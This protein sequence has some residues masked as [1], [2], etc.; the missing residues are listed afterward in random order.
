[1]LIER[2]RKPRTATQPD[3]GIVYRSESEFSGWPFLGGLWRI[4]SGQIV[5]AFT[6]LPCA[7]GGEADVHHNNLTVSQ[8]LVSII[9]SDDDGLTWKPDSVQTVFDKAMTAE[10]IA[11][12]GEPDYASEPAV[13][14]QSADTLV[15]SGGIPGLFVPSSKPWICL[16][17]DG[18]F[19]WRRPTLLDPESLGSLSGHASVS[20]RADGVGLIALTRVTPDGWTR[21]P[22]VYASV[23][24]AR[25][26]NFLS[27]VTPEMDDG[28]AVSP[29]EGSPRFGAHRYFYPRPLPLRDGRI[30]CSMRSQRN[31]TGVLWTEI[32][33]SL[34]G[35]R[36][37]SFLS[38]VNDWGAPGDIVEMADG[39]IVCVYGYRLA[40][41]GA[42]ARVSLDG[43][44]TW[45]SEL[46][47]RDDGGSW[48]LGYPRVMEVEPGRVMAVYYFNSKDDPVQLNGGVRHV[49]RTIFTP[50]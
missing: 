15:L 35:G 17:A 27:F 42:R 9:R 10:E 33:E 3:H 20:V 11:A 34:D 48:D 43:G 1:M 29:R 18:G 50:D 23:D 14:L 37:W 40:T 26:W 31:P 22:L 16:S 12:R 32:F 2:F 46:V 4:G 41:F 39:R 13:D 25:T 44:K 19:T 7:Y 45:E 21:R 24:G 8:G 28:T 30:I 47:L 6:R 49:A 36:T 38:R 5:S